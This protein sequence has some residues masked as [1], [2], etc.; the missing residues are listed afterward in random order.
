MSSYRQWILEAN[1]LA[2][3]SVQIPDWPHRDEEGK[4]ILD[5]DGKPVCTYY[6]RRMTLGERNAFDM[7]VSGDGQDRSHFFANL[8]GR[9]L[10]DEN[11]VRIFSDDDIPALEAKSCV[12]VHAMPIALRLNGLDGGPKN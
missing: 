3:E 4:V 8:L 2:R 1:D 10:C 6:V 12:C 11:G 7:A 5:A 9:T